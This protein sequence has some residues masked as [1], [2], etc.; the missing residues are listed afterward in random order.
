[1]PEIVHNYI[2]PNG[3]MQEDL[4][5][6]WKPEE[7]HSDKPWNEGQWELVDSTPFTMKG[8]KQT[9]HKDDETGQEFYSYEWVN[10]RKIHDVPNNY[11]FV[12][13]RGRVIQLYGDD[14]TNSHSWGVVQ[15]GQ[16]ALSDQ[17]SSPPPSYVTLGNSMSALQGAG[18]EYIPGEPHPDH[19]QG[20]D[21]AKP[22][23]PTLHITLFQAGLC[24]GCFPHPQMRNTH[25]TYHTDVYSP[26]GETTKHIFL[27][28]VPNRLKQLHGPYVIR[29]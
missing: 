14:S 25:I 28:F 29:F 2:D 9:Q 16:A 21:F 7:P 1:M 10:D 3:L 4:D 24:S 12:D 13:T 23:G 26:G 8:W 22:Q 11:S 20:R 27:E 18:Y 5:W 19:W 17:T 6:R 15:A